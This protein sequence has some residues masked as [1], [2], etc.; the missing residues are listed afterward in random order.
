M[1]LSQGDIWEGFRPTNV[2]SERKYAVRYHPKRSWKTSVRVPKGKAIYTIFSEEDHQDLVDAINAVSEE[3][4]RAPGGVFYVNEYK[5]V[6]KPISEAPGEIQAR[7][8]GEFPDLKFKFKLEDQ[9]MDTSDSSGLKTGDDWP[10]HK[11]GVRYTISPVDWRISRQMAVLMGNTIREEPEYLDEHI[12][13]YSDL[14]SALREVKP[15]GGIFYVNEHGL[16]FAPTDYGEKFVKKIDISPTI[17]FPKFL[18]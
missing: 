9:L 17:W 5:Q 2:S 11:V 8:V 12:E 13:D 1:P 18:G 14:V 15:N 7:Y 10:Y 4:L 3:F 16:V 6:L